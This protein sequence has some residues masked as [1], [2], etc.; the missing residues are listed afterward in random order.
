M[1]RRSFLATLPLAAAIEC[2]R[3]RAGCALTAWRSPIELNP[4]PFIAFARFRLS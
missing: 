2:A 4:H 3:P 1:R